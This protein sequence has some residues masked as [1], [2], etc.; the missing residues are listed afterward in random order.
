MPLADIEIQK[1]H[2][3]TEPD[4]V[5]KVAHGSAEHHAKPPEQQLFAALRDSVDR[6]VVLPEGYSMKVFGEQESQQES[7]EALAEYMPLTLVLILIVLL[8]LL[9]N[10]REPVVILLMIPLIFIGVVNLWDGYGN[11]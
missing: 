6:A 4:A 3:G 9:R 10:Y 11:L 8:L 7:N 5:H 1:I 2:N